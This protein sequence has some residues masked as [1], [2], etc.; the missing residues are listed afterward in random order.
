[1]STLSLSP[2]TTRKVLAAIVAF[3]L[4]SF[5]I[6]RTSEAAFTAETTN[7]DNAFA[8]GGITLTDDFTNPMFDEEFL[9]PGDVIEECILITYDGT[10]DVSTLSE[11]T[12]AVAVTGANTN[13]L[14]DELLVQADDTASCLDTPSYGSAVALADFPTAP[15]TGWTPAASGETRGFHFRVEVG[16]GAPQNSMTNGVNVTWEIEASA[17]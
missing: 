3:L 12:L 9:V 10:V 17:S 14:A 5:A 16:S 15:G 7:P 2:T 8:T 11:V 6:I 1:V 4:V 13:G